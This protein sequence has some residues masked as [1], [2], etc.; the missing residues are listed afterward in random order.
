MSFRTYQAV[1]DH[2]ALPS[3]EKFL[4]SLIAHSE[5][6]KTGQCNPSK[7][8]LAFYHNTK[9]RNLRK[10][11]DMLVQA[12][13]LVIGRQRGRSNHYIIPLYPDEPGFYDPGP[14][15]ETDQHVCNG[16]HG[17]LVN[18]TQRDMQNNPRWLAQQSRNQEEQRVTRRITGAVP[19]DRGRKG[20]SHRTGGEVPQDRG[21]RS[22]RTPRI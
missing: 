1:L 12:G 20:R 14:C 10:R 5:N 17:P 21:G 6:E 3:S 18:R 11:I 8:V 22:H 7:R 16:H 4:L 19:Q 13:E 9:E 2:C 15:Q